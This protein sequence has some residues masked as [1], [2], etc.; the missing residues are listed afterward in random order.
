MNICPKCNQKFNQRPAKSR[1]DGSEIC[2]LCGHKEA[3]DIAYSNGVL[4]E[5][6]TTEILKLLQDINEQKN[7]HI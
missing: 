5:T 6:E 4:N 3:I 7:P 2:P 1:I